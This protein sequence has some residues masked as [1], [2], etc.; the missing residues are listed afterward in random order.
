MD[1]ATG[2]VMWFSQ[3]KGFGYIRRDDGADVFVH[4]S[5]IQG[6]GFRTLEQGESVEF[7]VIQEPK[8][9]KAANVLRLN[10]PAG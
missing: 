10:P 2:T 8:G 6:R 9:L 4:S 1:R 5:A 3:E 7:D